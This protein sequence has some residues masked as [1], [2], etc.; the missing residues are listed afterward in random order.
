MGQLALG[1]RSLVV[2]SVVFFALAAALVWVLGGTL[3]P[4]PER[5]DFPAIS[6]ASRQWHV[7][8]SVGGDHPGEVRY[9]LMSAAP[10]GE[11]VPFGGAF[12]DTSELVATPEFLVTAMRRLPQDGGGWVLR[13]IDAAGH[14]STEALTSRLAAEQ[15]LAARREAAA[16][17]R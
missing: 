13:V 10:H 1:L 4:R 8:L 12:A 16:P 5:V 14:E 17:G 9:E 6:F 15:A 7:R 3:F 11:P 2:R